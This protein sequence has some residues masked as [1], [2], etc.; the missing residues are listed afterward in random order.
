[1]TR[2]DILNVGSNAN[3]THLERFIDSYKT[4]PF[5]SDSHWLYANCPS[6]SRF[7][8]RSSVP[9]ALIPSANLFGLLPP[10]PINCIRALFKPFF[11]ETNQ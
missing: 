7:C 4:T 8:R 9:S 6:Q 5:S 1:M 10:L 11:G 3:P 2:I